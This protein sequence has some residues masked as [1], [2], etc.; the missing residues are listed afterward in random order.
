M[1]IFCNWEKTLIKLCVIQNL[2]EVTCLTKAMNDFNT[3]ASSRRASRLAAI[4]I[5][6]SG[7]IAKSEAL[8]S[9]LSALTF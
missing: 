6:L 3:L 7:Q 8:S 9:F 4:S 2:E 5:C 1:S